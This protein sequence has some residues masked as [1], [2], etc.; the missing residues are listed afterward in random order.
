MDV[1]GVEI[2]QLLYRLKGDA[3]VALTMVSHEAQ[4]RYVQGRIVEIDDVIAKLMST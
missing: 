4:R 2:L 3:H 1:L